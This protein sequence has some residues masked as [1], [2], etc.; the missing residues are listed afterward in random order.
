MYESNRC[1]GCG[2]DLPP[3]F[4]KGFHCADCLRTTMEKMTPEDWERELR[5]VFD[6]V[7]GTDV[8]PGRDADQ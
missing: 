5:A 3:A 4:P 6:H 1:P 7:T 2:T 8:D